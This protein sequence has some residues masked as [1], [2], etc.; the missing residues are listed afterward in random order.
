MTD[1]KIRRNTFRISKVSLFLVGCC[2]V[3]VSA[4]VYF[5]VQYKAVE[6]EKN[7]NAQLVAKIGQV[8]QLPSETPMIVTVADRSR[9][10]NRQLASKVEDG[11]TMFIFARAKR[12][13]V[14]R[15]ATEK[16]VDM[17]SFGSESDMP[18][19]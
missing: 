6:G 1:E 7:A 11:D 12:L 13:I 16:V 3:A 14:Y 19:Q 15:P 10:S 8:V 4:G 5:F 17:L 9:L 2:I 18:K